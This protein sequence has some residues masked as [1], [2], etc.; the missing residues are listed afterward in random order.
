MHPTLLPVSV[1]G[2]ELAFDARGLLA[3]AG[4]IAALALF[5]RRARAAG[6]AADVAGGL[7]FELGLVALAAG[8]LA[9][10]ALP[11]AAGAIGCAAALAWIAARAP[12][13]GLPARRAA[14]LAAPGLAL[15]AALG[16]VGCF[17]AGCCFGGA[18][19]TAPGVHFPPESAAYQALFD[20]GRL[21]RDRAAT[22]A[23]HPVQ[24][25]EAAGHA[26]LLLAVLA[27]GAWPRALGDGGA[28]ALLL[29]GEALVALLVQPLRDQASRGSLAVAVATAALLACA[30]V[31]VTRRRT[32]APG[33]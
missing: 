15:A 27:A 22:G 11:A 28:A 9:H 8:R 33:W 29:G 13:R 10:L 21:A 2:R 19:G 25:Y 1:L 20:A 16:A 4:A 14:D 17:L 30:A 24:L 23:L 32:R 6:V 12:R 26:A 31:V 7:A 18:A 5:L 3:V